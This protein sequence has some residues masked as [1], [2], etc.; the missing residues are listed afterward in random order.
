[1]NEGIEIENERGLKARLIAFGARLTHLWIPD[2]KGNRLDVVQ[3]FDNDASYLNK[4]RNHY[5]GATVGRYANRIKHGET[6]QSGNLIQ[7]SKNAGKHHL[8]GGFRGFDLQP[9]TLKE[10]LPHSVTFSLKSSDGDE[11]Y[12][13]NLIAEVSYRLLENSLHVVHKAVSDQNTLVN[14]THHSYFNLNGEQ[15]NTLDGHFFQIQAEQMVEVDS[16]GIA[17]GRIIPLAETAF[18]YR[19]PKTLQAPVDACYVVG[20]EGNVALNLAAT[21]YSEISGL[22]MQLFA[23]QPGLQFY[24][25]TFFDGSLAGKGG[26]PLAYQGSFCLEPQLF[27]CSPNYALFPN[28]WLPA[29]EVYSNKMIFEF[30]WK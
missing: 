7:L 25:A 22:H 2:A 6:W 23:H 28:A 29:G 5:I 15:Y 13:G 19:N 16:Q 24:S 27:P 3:G 9:W 10:H 18:D 8:H 14:L 1:M 21:V 4:Q 17:T 12:P 26:K 30:D 11:G 20:K